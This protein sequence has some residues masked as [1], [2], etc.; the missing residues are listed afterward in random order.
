MDPRLTVI[1]IGFQAYLQEG[2]EDFG[3]VREVAPDGRDEIVIYVE[4]AGDFIVP[5]RAIRGAHDGKVILDR[6]HL[7]QRLRAAIAHAHDREEPG[8]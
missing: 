8:L 7:D 6:A 2:G 1:E 4:N 5:L 3:A